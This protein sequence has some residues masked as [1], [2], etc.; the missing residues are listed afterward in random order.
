MIYVQVVIVILVVLFSK[1]NLHLF[2]LES[3][4]RRCRTE[5]VVWEVHLEEYTTKDNVKVI[6]SSEKY[7]WHS[8]CFHIGW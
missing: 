7:V 3:E 6:M 5:K 2:S 8:C 1:K 4:E